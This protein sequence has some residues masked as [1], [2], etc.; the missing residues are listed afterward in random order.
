MAVDN[1]YDRCMEGMTRIKSDFEDY[2]RVV[3]D[4]VNLKEKK[5]EK[6]VERE[7]KKGGK[8]KYDGNEDLEDN[9]EEK[10][11]NSALF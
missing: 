2:Q 3:G 8:D 10:S 9:Y 1:L 6:K 7:K 11:K 5:T 4:K